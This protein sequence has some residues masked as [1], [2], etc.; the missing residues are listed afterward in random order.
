MKILMYGINQDTISKDEEIIYDFSEEDKQLQLEAIQKF[1]GVKE[2]V[3]FH[4]RYRIEYY[5][6]VDESVFQHG[7][8]LRFVSEYTD[9]P[10]NEVILQMYSLFN[11]DVVRH[12]YELA[13]GYHAENRGSL[14]NLH[15]LEENLAFANEHHSVGPILNDLFSRVISFAYRTKMMSALGPLLLDD[16]LS[17][18]KRLVLSQEQ[19]K[20]AKIIVM[21]ECQ[22]IQ[23]LGKIFAASQVYSLTLA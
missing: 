19:L 15:I 3:I 23:Y 11:E 2:V 4:S 22:G 13:T 20:K 12:L 8:L 17:L 21:G 14:E 18:I 6:H 10:L 5:F 7:D 9:K 1:Q 16:K